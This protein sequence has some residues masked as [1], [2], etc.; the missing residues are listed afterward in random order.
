MYG[1]TPF[2]LGYDFNANETDGGKGVPILTELT[3]LAKQAHASLEPI[4]VARIL[5]VD[6]HPSPDRDAEFGLVE[7]DNGSAGLYYA[8]LGESQADMQA[9]FTARD[10]TR[11]SPL[12]LV[13]Y[14]AHDSD[15]ERS[16]GLA[17]INALTDAFYRAVRYSPPEAPDSMGG[18]E[19]ESGDHVG[20]VGN[21]L[22]LVRKLAASGIRTT[23]VERK[24][25]MINDGDRVRVTL[26]PTKLRDCNKIICTGAT[27]LNNSL[28]DMLEYCRQADVIALLGPTVGFFPDP[29]FARGI[30]R[31][32]GIRLD[33][34]NG[35][36]ARL[37]SGRKVGDSAIRTLITRDEYPGFDE[38]RAHA[39]VN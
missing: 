13:G 28:D 6:P 21:F 29:L 12:E 1:Y 34:A 23:V 38:L 10:L 35:A 25:H 19:F 14:T 31:V 16:L 20:M 8:W 24:A 37:A 17:T 9:Q 11:L 15:A 2:L 33:D 4:T 18:L 32:G 26:D 36:Y 3:T 5:I 22:P 30:D 27:L 7:L 39:S